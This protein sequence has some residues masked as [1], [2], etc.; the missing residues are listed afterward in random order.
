MKRNIPRSGL[1]VFP[2]TGHA[3]NL[4]EPAIFNRM[5]LDFLT[6]VEAGRW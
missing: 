3:I 6:S 5:V 2:Q 1:V 4:E